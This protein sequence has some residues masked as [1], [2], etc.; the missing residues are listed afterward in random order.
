MSWVNDE[1]KTVHLGDTRLDTR[2]KRILLDLGDKPAQSIPQAM[3][4][5]AETMAAYRFFANDKVTYEH[6]LQPHYDATLERIKQQKVVLLPQDTTDFIRVI[7]KG[8]NGIG[9]LK[10]TEKEEIFFHPTIAITPEKIPLGTVAFDLW[11]RPEQSVRKDHQDKPIEEKESYLWIEGYQNACDIQAQA[12]DTLIVNIADREGDIYEFFLEMLDYAPSQ[13]AAWII[14]AA[15][16]RCLESDDKTLPKLQAQLKQAPVLGESTFNIPAQTGKAA[17]SVRQAIHATM[18]QL[19]PPERR[20]MKGFK[21]PPVTIN[22]VFA[23][24]IN[25]PANQK[26]VNWLLLTCLPVETFEQVSLIL[27]WYA[28]R[29]EIE[30]FFR[31]LKQGCKI[32]KLQFESAKNFAACLAFYVIIAWRILYVTML[33]RDYP[34]I[35]CEVVFD[36]DEWQTLYIIE[37]REP[38][39]EKPPPL[40]EMILIVAKLG[41]FLARKGDGVPGPQPIWIGLQRLRDFVWAIQSYKATYCHCIQEAKT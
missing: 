27:Q 11:K 12:P 24:E 35:D 36:K 41:G 29:W 32:E 22:V 38:P 17:R 3:G 7:N 31:V 30:I 16:D 19:K 20:F 15:Q 18:V 14:R 4:G 10:H 40:H 21:L 37:K 1:V 34:N 23:E 26:P 5:W 6:V 9:T 28:A 13:R 39:P 33:G 2:M 8:S 25:P